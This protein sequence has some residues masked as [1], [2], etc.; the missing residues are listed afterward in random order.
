MTTPLTQTQFDVLYALLREDAPLTQRDLKARTGISLGRVNTAVRECEALGYIDAR[1]LTD[2]GRRALDPYKVDNAVIMA[3]GLSSR[4]APISY[5]RPKGTL[6]VRGEVLIERQ[7]RQLHEVGITDITVVVGYKKEYFFSL[8]DA[9]GVNIVVN[10]DYASRNNNGSLW[11]VRDRLANTY[12]CSSD[13][14]FTVNPFESHVYR[15]YYSAVHVDGPTDEWCLS[16]GPGGRITGATIGGADAWTMLGHV[17]FDREFSR[18]FAAILERVYHRPETAPKLWESI[19]LDHVKDLDMVIRRYPDGVINEF[20]SVDE[21]RDFDPNFIEN[22]DSEAFDNIAGALGCD[23][24]DIHDFAPLKQGITNLSCRFRLGDDQYVYRHPGAGTDKIVDRDA[25]FAA[26]EL[27]RDIGV[28]RTYIAGDPVKGWKI[29]RFV[30]DA[31]NL[32]VTDEA[33]L[34]RAMRMSRSLHESDH[35]LAR[36]FDFVAEGLRYEDL[37]AREGAICVPGYF[38]LRDKV[39]RLKA[40]TEADGYGLVPSHN[41]FFPPNFLVAPDGSIDLI[42]WEY[43]G[44]SDEASDFGT[45]VVCTADMDDDLADTALVHYF[46]RTPTPLEHRHF[47]AHVVFAGWCWYVWALLKEAEGD[48]VGEWLLTYYR[49]AAD[50]IDPLLARYEAAA[51]QEA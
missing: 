33:E 7:I 23:K 50:Y 35:R 37:L 25:E 28:D 36:R 18:R 11:L 9:F 20:D 24:T 27:A 1:A 44:M 16:T 45:M 30:P 8:I 5:E 26:L 51:G 14:Y 41:D 43:A 31:R 29:S 12:V 19:Y 49:H 17:Y 13:D 3:A 10:R 22:I 48:D 15:A 6:R 2:A 42:D 40:F 39:L 4:F 34:A 38:E 46:G 47:W 32:D 21:L